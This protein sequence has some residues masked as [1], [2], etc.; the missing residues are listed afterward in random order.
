MKA[1]IISAVRGVHRILAYRD[2]PDRVA[3]MFHELLERQW[4][5]FR[6][7]IEALGDEGFS[8]VTPADYCAAPSEDSRRLLITFDD[9]FQQWHRALCLFDDVGI[10]ATFYTNSGPFRDRA[11]PSEI[12]AFFE[13]IAHDED[14][15][16]LSTSELREI[17]AAGHTIGC[18]THW[19]EALQTV[20]PA[21]WD[22]V[23]KRS[24]ETLEDI[25]GEPVVDFAYPYGTRRYFS[26]PLRAYCRGL[27]FERI[28]EG[29]PGRLHQRT[30]DPYALQRTRWNL[31]KSLDRNLDD[32]RIDGQLFEGLTGRSAIG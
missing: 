25:L 15:V 31:D 3:V 23:I 27:G 10:T 7:A 12:A 8:S 22:D 16:P 14:P 11:S 24:K 6:E 13:R 17:R 30:F 28:A 18:H 4:P 9:N 2:Y 1:Q 21:Q 19:H 5:A 26:E 20:P 32:L 29:R